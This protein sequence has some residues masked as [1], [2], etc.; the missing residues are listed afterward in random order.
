ME[1]VYVGLD[2]GS[3]SFQQVAISTGGSVTTNRNFPAASR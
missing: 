2:L 3:S 1:T